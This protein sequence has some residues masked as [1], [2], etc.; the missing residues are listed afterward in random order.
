MKPVVFLR[1]SPPGSGISAKDH[2]IRNPL[3]GLRSSLDVIEGECEESSQKPVQEF[4]ELA[5]R[6][7]YRADRLIGEFLEFAKARPPQQGQVLVAE[8]LANIHPL[9]APESQN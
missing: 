9:I 1:N 8:F 3:A 5:R 2:E 6:E 4:F 7:F